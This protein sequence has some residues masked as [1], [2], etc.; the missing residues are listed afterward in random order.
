MSHISALFSV[1][2]KQG[3][4]DNGQ[5]DKSNA[6]YTTSHGLNYTPDRFAI[7]SQWFLLCAIRVWL[8]RKF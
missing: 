5:S 6:E 3:F 2:F 7:P 8:D 1:E 4:Y